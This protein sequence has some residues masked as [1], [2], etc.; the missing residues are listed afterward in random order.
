MEYKYGLCQI[1]CVQSQG[2]YLQ[3]TND[4]LVDFFKSYLKVTGS[5][6]LTK[7]NLLSANIV[8]IAD[9]LVVPSLTHMIVYDDRYI[10]E[11]YDIVGATR[12]VKGKWSFDL[13]LNTFYTFND[14]LRACEFF[15]NRQNNLLTNYSHLQSDYSFNQVQ[16]KRYGI[17]KLSGLSSL[18]LVYDGT[19]VEDGVTK[20]SP[21]DIQLGISIS[22]SGDYGP[23]FPDTR[24]LLPRSNI[25]DL[26]G[27]TDPLDKH[28][29]I[30]SASY[31]S[32]GGG[33]TPY[34]QGLRVEIGGKL[35]F[36]NIQSTNSVLQRNLQELV[37]VINDV[38]LYY[39]DFLVNQAGSW[40]KW[41]D[42]EYALKD[43]FIDP[44][45]GTFYELDD[46]DPVIVHNA[47]ELSLSDYSSSID[48]RPFGDNRFNT[49]HNL[50]TYIIK[51]ALDLAN[52]NMVDDST[53]SATFD[54][55]MNGP[56]QVNNI[57]N[58]TYGITKGSY[59]YDI[60]NGGESVRVQPVNTSDLTAEFV[61]K[62]ND[63]ISVTPAGLFR[64]KF[65]FYIYNYVESTD[66]NSAVIELTLT[67]E[68]FVSYAEI[69]LP[70][71]VDQSDQGRIKDIANDIYSAYL[72][73]KV[74]GA[75]PSKSRLLNVIQSPFVMSEM[76]N[77]EILN[78]VLQ[79]DPTV[80]KSVSFTTG[81]VLYKDLND[82]YLK[83]PFTISLD[84]DARR[85]WSRY[86]IEIQN[87]Q[88]VEIRPQQ[89]P[90]LTYEAILNQACLDVNIYANEVRI[91]NYM[92]VSTV[93]Q[94][95]SAWAE[96]VNANKNYKENFNLEMEKL[97]FDR[98]IQR[99][100]N[101]SD[102]ALNLASTGVK[103]GM[104]LA[105]GGD[106]TGLGGQFIVDSAIKTAQVGVNE[107]FAEKAHQY[108]LNYKEQIFNNAIE[109]I[110]AQRVKLANSNNINYTNNGLTLLQYYPQDFE[111]ERGLQSFRRL[112]WNINRYWISLSDFIRNNET[113]DLLI[114]GELYLSN[115]SLNEDIVQNLKDIVRRGVHLVIRD[116]GSAKKG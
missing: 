11:Y 59:Y 9:D 14:R 78:G 28:F 112:G 19:V 5:A 58:R 42:H 48:N 114:Q 115:V 77:L 113:E 33:A 99:D 104:A 98:N 35:Y 31:W 43:R 87:N 67:P 17:T 80:H 81:R 18:I 46:Q 107:Y 71:S 70:G 62:V 21:V 65:P 56:K 27:P 85:L 109:N 95:Q 2:E 54:W 4:D 50:M 61:A 45:T 7:I 89:I 6:K 23:M 1:P 49:L 47:S 57:T 110:E 10:Y 30:T 24:L 25:N 41:Y 105:G 88:I 90:V 53:S 63:L 52:N 8:L 74:T 13:Q 108:N 12:G 34:R 64:L 20:L 86:Y 116:F 97:Q 91:A 37:S 15:Q 96:F 16:Y 101:Y 44:E 94:N 93:P 51:Q 66:V 32:Q 106:P 102:L 55:M 22:R 3:F 76:R 92:I 82:D 36:I 73:T 60:T 39:R 68:K 29:I 72:I 75:D 84:D 83:E 100:K 69:L 111:L 79:E 26:V 40:F 38:G 103:A